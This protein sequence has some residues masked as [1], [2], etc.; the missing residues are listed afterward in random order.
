MQEEDY[1]VLRAISRC[2]EDSW[3]RTPEIKPKMEYSVENDLEHSLQT[4]EEKDF[5]RKSKSGDLYKIKKDGVNL[6]QQRKLDDSIRNLEWTIGKLQAQQARSSAVET[7]FTLAL[8]IFAAFQ[9]MPNYDNRLILIGVGVPVI[10]ALLIGGKNLSQVTIDQIQRLIN[11]I[12]DKL[13]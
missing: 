1:E 6:V 5:I 8:L 12:L 3:I 7:V 4:L 9:I 2:K 11:Y 10:W 13:E